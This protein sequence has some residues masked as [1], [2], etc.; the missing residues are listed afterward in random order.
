MMTLEELT[1][2]ELAA[3]E[4]YRK[5]RDSDNEYTPWIVEGMTEIE[6]YHRLYLTVRNQLGLARELWSDLPSGIK[7]SLMQYHPVVYTAWQKVM[8]A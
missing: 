8:E 6:W 3:L 7:E 2:D 5:E 1:A 4:K